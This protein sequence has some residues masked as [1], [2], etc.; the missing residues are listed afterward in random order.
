MSR[1]P[2]LGWR[3]VPLWTFARRVERSGFPDEQLLSVYRDWGGVVRRA[4]RDDNFNVASDDLSSYKLVRRGDL[5]LN[6]MKT[7]QGSLGVSEYDGIV[8]PAYFVCELSPAV[9]GRF[10]HHLLRSSYTTARFAA[11]S[12]GIRPNQWDL[13]FDE[14]RA[15][16]VAIPPIDEQRRIADFLDGQVA[17]LDGA[18]A[19]RSRQLALITD[20]ELEY[21]R[22]MTTTGGFGAATRPTG[23]AW[24]PEIQSKWAVRRLAGLFATGGSG[25]T[26]RSDRLEYYGGGRRWVTSGDLRDGPHRH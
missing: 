23:I 17:G 19:A 11:A 10:V 2:P 25:T 8:S 24:M 16:N 18:I 6:K 20:L 9:H 3:R 15:M 7:W 4:D 1:Q 13:P 22:V 14:L 12:K 26:P 5:V 21:R